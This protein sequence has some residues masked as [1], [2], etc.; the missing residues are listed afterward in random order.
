VDDLSRYMWVAVIPSKDCVAAAIKEIQAQVEGK[1]SLKLRALRIDRG[2]EFTMREFVEYCMTTGVHHQRTVPYNPQQNGII[3]R[4]NGTVV[5]TARSMLKAKSLLGWFWGEAVST[6]V[7]VLNRCL[8]K[9]VDGMAWEESAMHHLRMFGC[10]IYVR[11]TTPHLK[12]L[13]DRCYKMIFIGDESGSKAYRVY[14]PV[15]KH[16]YVTCDMVFNE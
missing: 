3:E 1:S 8:T 13:E 12:K 5:A 9:S 6:T 16:V 7:Y 15:T 14:D 10:I 11:N 2:G 4:R